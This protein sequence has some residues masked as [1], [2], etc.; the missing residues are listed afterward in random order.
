MDEFIET[1][2]RVLTYWI[3][4]IILVGCIGAIGAF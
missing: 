2:F 4:G 3:I 1:F